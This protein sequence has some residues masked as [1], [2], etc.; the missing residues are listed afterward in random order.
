MKKLRILTTLIAGAMLLASCGGT[1]SSSDPASSAPSMEPS[2]SSSAASF[3][4]VDDVP[5]VE[6]GDYLFNYKHVYRL[7]K[8]N[9]KL[10]VLDFGMEYNRYK[11]GNGDLIAESNLRFV[12]LNGARYVLFYLNE[13]PNLLYKDGQ[14]TYYVLKYDGD[15][16]EKTAINKLPEE[17]VMPSYGTYVS[18]KEFP[19]KKVNAQGERELDSQG[20]YI[21]ETFY[22]FLD[23]TPTEAKLYV[24]ENNETHA[25]TPLHA[26]S[27]YV[28]YFNLGGLYIKIPHEGSTVT[29]GVTITSST[30]MH[31]NNSWEKD[32]DYSA[33]GTFS[34]IL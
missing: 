15:Y 6:S 28:L 9:K 20:N 5:T 27:N 4:D 11:N 12:E 21:Y 29:T 30:T 14:G 16:M 22:L 3:V 7:D 8:A 25:E 26:I 33:S 24:G 32:G 23:L 17:Y 31:V 18:D 34:L 1:P 10:K 13:V 19:Q 2:S